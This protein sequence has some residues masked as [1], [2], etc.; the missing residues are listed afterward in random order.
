MNDLI[1]GGTGLISTEI[2]GRA[3]AAGYRVTV[4]N[5]GQTP[6]PL[7]ESV[8][9]IA[10]DRRDYAA[11][12]AAVKDAG[13]FD[14]VVDMITF[15]QADAESLVRACRGSSPRVLFCSTVDVYE[16]ERPPRIPVPEDAPRRGIGAYAENE[17]LREAVLEQAAAAS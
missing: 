9:P 6:I 17:V 4:F 14:A 12:E 15:T 11:F 7:P 5:R 1:V 8:T 3:V 10:G 13:P 2:V 16:K